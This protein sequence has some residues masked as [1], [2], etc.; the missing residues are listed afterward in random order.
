[1]RQGWRWFGPGDPVSLDDVRQ[2][3]ATDVVHGASPDA[4]REPWTREAVLEAAGH[5]RGRQRSTDGPELDRGREHPRSR[6][7]Q[8]RCARARSLCRGLHPIDGGCG[9]GRNPG[10]LLQFHAGD[11]LD[12]H[13]SRL[14]T[15]DRR[16][17]ARGSTPTPS[18][19]SIS[20]SCSG[21]APSAS[22]SRTKSS[23]ANRR[24]R[25]SDAEE[26][27]APRAEHHRWPAGRHVG[28]L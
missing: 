24:M 11:R 1:M 8:G 9:G 10:H 14:G 26:R 16:Q 13:G 22:T 7:R 15:A 25:R 18:P 21:P 17:G 28:V 23:G 3:G 6:R 20:S 4:D 2:A 19:P 12:A 27:D 5:R